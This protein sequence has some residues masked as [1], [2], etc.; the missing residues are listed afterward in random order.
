MRWWMGPMWLALACAGED[1]AVVHDPSEPGPYGVGHETRVLVDSTRGDRTLPLQVWYPGVVTEGAESTEYELA[2]GIGLPSMIAF[3]ALAAADSGPF[4]LL[5]FSHGYAGINTQSVELC[6][7]LASHG[8][9][10]VSPEHAGNAQ[11]DDGDAFEVAAAN[12][13]PDVSFVIDAMT[14]ANADGADVLAG[15]L[16]LES[17]GVVGHSFGGMTSLGVASGWAGA[18]GDERVRAIAPISAVVDGGLQED[19]RPH[20]YAGFTE[21]QLVS[22]TVPAM[23]I[24]GTLDVNV[25]I[26]NN[27]IAFAGI[28]SSRAVYMLDVIGATHTRFANVCQIGDRLIELGIQKGAWDAIGAGALS[29]PYA[30]SCEGEAL[31]VSEVQRLTNT[32]TVS[33]FRRHLDGEEGYDA[34]LTEEW[35][36][37]EPDASFVRRVSE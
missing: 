18:S 32:A 8:F 25:P 31:A 16:D 36:D 3:E 9:V 17:I 27:E 29:G 26:E 24:G 34:W 5:V 19:E 1:P 30:E 33:F 13:V 35:A 22:I 7:V 20:P 28:T 11:G 12:R 23:L 21:A 10:V 14:D 4:G 15:L 37:Q 2:A 6:E